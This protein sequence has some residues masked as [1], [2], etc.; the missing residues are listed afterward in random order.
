VKF[1][2]SPDTGMDLE[3]SPGKIGDKNYECKFGMIYACG[4]NSF[5]SGSDNYCGGRLGFDLPPVNR[6]RNMLWFS[7]HLQKGGRLC[8]RNDIV[9]NKSLPSC[10]N[11]IAKINVKFTETI[12][13]FFPCYHK[14]NPPSF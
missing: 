14:E 12:I 13:S 1:G 11:A 10:V 2:V 4:V 6:S 5:P 3:I 9:L 7:D 8:E